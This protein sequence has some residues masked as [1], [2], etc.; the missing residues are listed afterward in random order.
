MGQTRRR[1]FEHVAGRTEAAKE[2]GKQLGKCLHEIRMAIPLI[3][4]R[5]LLQG[6]NISVPEAGCD[7]FRVKIPVLADPVL[8]VVADELEIPAFSFS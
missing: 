4:A 2:L 8:D 6:D 1:Q 7:T 3:I 5:D